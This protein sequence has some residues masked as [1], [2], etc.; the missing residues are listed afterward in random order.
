MTQDDDAILALKFALCKSED[1]YASFKERGDLKALVALLSGDR[2]GPLRA[3]GLW[4]LAHVATR[5]CKSQSPAAGPSTAHPED[6]P[7]PN[8]PSPVGEL[9]LKE[10]QDL[11]LSQGQATTAEPSTTQPL[12]SHAQLLPDLLELG[13]VAPFIQALQGLSAQLP[14]RVL[15]HASQL[16]LMVCADKR[17]L[18]AVTDAP[19][20]PALLA[21]LARSASPSARRAGIKGLA[22]AAAAP[23][24]RT[25]LRT[26]KA[27]E[28]FAG[29]FFDINFMPEK[30]WP[31]PQAEPLPNFW[32]AAKGLFHM[33]SVIDN[34]SPVRSIPVSVMTDS[35]ERRQLD[36]PVTEVE[37]TAA[38]PNSLAAAENPVTSDPLHP[39]QPFASDMC[40]LL[41]QAFCEGHDLFRSGAVRGLVDAFKGFQDV[42]ARMGLLFLVEGIVRNVRAPEISRELLQEGL[43]G[44]IVTF[45]EREDLEVIHVLVAVELLMSF[46]GD[47][48]ALRV[49]DKRGAE[50]ALKGHRGRDNSAGRAAR[51]AIV[52][53]GYLRDPWAWHFARG[54]ARLQDGWPFFDPKSF[55]KVKKPAACG[56]LPGMVVSVVVIDAPGRNCWFCQEVLEDGYGTAVETGCICWE[57]GWAR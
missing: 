36:A 51:V 6:I 37:Q 18:A 10:M 52:L 41:A 56:G 55:H 46:I 11:R 29:Q 54:T 31:D 2:S 25:A 26:E 1:D 43:V 15:R 33:V 45:L 42:D 5:N 21:S 7:P 49:A 57:E 3:V 23:S 50:P 35:L 44:Q 28:I 12:P 48:G 4:S 9:P 14:E 30:D 8:R 20:G 27:A 47:R 24:A 53:L 38:L 34:R 13:F 22:L 39:A 32:W 19:G 17:G 40:G 16:L